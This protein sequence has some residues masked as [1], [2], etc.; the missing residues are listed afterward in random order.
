MSKTFTIAF[1]AIVALQILGVIAFAAIKQNAIFS[2]THIILQQA[3]PV[4]PM[5]LMQGDYAILDYE[6]SILP[7]D[8]ESNFSAGD[9]V[10]VILEQRGGVWEA[11]GYHPDDTVA[12]Q[13]DDLFIR[14]RLQASGRIDFG[15]GTYFVPEGT[16]YRIERA[17]DVKIRVSLSD[18]GKATVTG[19]ILDGEDFKP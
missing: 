12:K 19:V 17:G 8:R 7:P 11:V 6:I 1:F 13:F 15:I 9:D 16:G 5:S 10:V 18:E 2:G 3:A 14:G 4:D